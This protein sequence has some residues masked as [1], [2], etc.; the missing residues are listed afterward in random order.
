MAHPEHPEPFD[1]EQTMKYLRE[2]CRFPEYE[3][4]MILGEGAPEEQHERF[5]MFQEIVSDCELLGG[6]A[7]ARMMF[8]G[9]PESAPA[10]AGFAQDGF[11]NY[12]RMDTGEPV[13]TAEVFREAK[14]ILQRWSENPKGEHG[15]LL[16]SY[17]IG[18][19][20]RHRARQQA[21]PKPDPPADIGPVSRELNDLVARQDLDVRTITEIADLHDEADPGDPRSN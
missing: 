6:A 9:W 1:Y 16:D 12:Y 18:W 19:A 17:G 2:V 14:T 7:G 8:H 10:D 13:D 11:G 3:A 4:L 20:D 21:F 15:R 5:R